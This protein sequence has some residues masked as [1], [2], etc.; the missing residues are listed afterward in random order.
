ML[1]RGEAN[2]ASIELSERDGLLRSDG[3]EFYRVTLRENEFEVS[4]RVYAFDPA[5]DGLSKF[6]R[7]I[8]DKWRGWK[9]ILEWSSLEG[10]FELSCQHDGVGHVQVIATI[11]SNN[12]GNGWT[13]QIRFDVAPGSLEEIAEGVNRFF[14]TARV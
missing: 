8:A 6:F 3:S 14:K 9:G 11:H 13:G 7:A 2:G 4:F 10:E 12:F 5:D 1:I